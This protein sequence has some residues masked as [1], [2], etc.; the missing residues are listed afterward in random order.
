MGKSNP[1]KRGAHYHAPGLGGG[2]YGENNPQNPS[3]AQKV[4]LTKE[5]GQ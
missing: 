1:M 3:A 4:Q 2:F 5:N